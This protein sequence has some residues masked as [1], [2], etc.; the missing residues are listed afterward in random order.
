[1]FADDTSLSKAFQN[2]NK[3]CMELIQAFANICK[4]L[5]ANKLS[6]N[7]VKTEFMVIG[8]PQR[9]GQLDIALETTP[10]ALFVKD[11]SIRL[12]KQVKN[13]GLIIDENLTWD[14]HINYMW[15]KMK[16]NLGILKRMSKTLPTES[17]C[18]LYKTQ[19][20]PH[21]RYCSVVWENKDKLQ[22]LQN[23]ATRI[24]TRTTYDTANHYAL[25]RQL[26]WL[27][28]RSITR[29]EVGLFM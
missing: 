17:L 4:W 29:L 26:K 19:I 23:W 25:L 1:M 18:T 2:T 11:A 16:R 22:I 24:I 8:T 3:L 13:L 21:I 15:Q 10:Y 5:M 6:L 20:E 28:V 12:V 14:H 9:V 27:D 7:T